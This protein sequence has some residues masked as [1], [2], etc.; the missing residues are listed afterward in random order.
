[1]VASVAT[2]TTNSNVAL[3]FDMGWMSP[4]PT[5]GLLQASGVLRQGTTGEDDYRNGRKSTE[6]WNDAWGHPLVV[7]YA[8][9]QPERYVR[10]FDQQ[11]RRDKLLKDALKAYQY[12]RSVY[13]AVGAAG[14]SMPATLPLTWAAGSDAVTMRDYWM[15]IRD[16]SG[17][18]AWNETAFSAPPWKG[19]K[20]GK[21]NGYTCYVSTPTEV[22]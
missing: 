5:I 9:F 21:K 11:N 13:L 6:P 18:A 22:K 3:P 7:V 14:G 16:V 12:N 10:N 20:R 4:L 19:L 15:Q 8:L 17:A 1:V 2:S